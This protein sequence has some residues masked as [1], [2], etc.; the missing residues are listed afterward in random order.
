MMMISE[1]EDN[2]TRVQGILDS[3]LGYLLSENRYEK[4]SKPV[5]IPY[6]K[7]DAISSKDMGGLCFVVK[8]IASQQILDSYCYKVHLQQLW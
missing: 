6:T 8:A 7:S 4:N 2:S 5:M 1:V 3:S